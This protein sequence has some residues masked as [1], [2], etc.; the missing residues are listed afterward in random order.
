LSAED[1]SKADEGRIEMKGKSVRT[2]KRGDSVTVHYIGTLDNGRIFDRTPDDTPL[3]FTIGAGEVFPALEEGV[4]GMAAGEVRNILLPAEKAYGP[5]RPENVVTLKR[6]QLPPGLEPKVG[7]KLQIRLGS[8]RELIMVVTALGE[9]EVTLDGNHALSGLD[10]TF[11]LRL[12][13]IDR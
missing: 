7:L 9:A 10:L 1:F 11:A 8:G 3:R 4:C 12:D 5:R 2:A 13:G 6:E